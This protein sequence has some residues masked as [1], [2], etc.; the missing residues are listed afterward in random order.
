M[1]RSIWIG[2]LCF[3]ACVGS[4]PTQDKKEEEKKDGIEYKMDY[5]DKTW[6]IKLKTTKI[7]NDRISILLT[8]SKDVEKLDEMRLAFT[9]ARTAKAQPTVPMLFYVF[10][11]DGVVLNKLNFG[12]MGELTGKEG[13]SFW[14][15]LVALNQLDSIKKVEPRPNPNR[16]DSKP[17][18]EPTKKKKKGG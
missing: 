15:V 18:D 16:A 14:V 1:I 17:E 2:L 11:K 10:D 8:F 6:G 7:E 12:T 9:P 13:D 3:V 4:A 5:L